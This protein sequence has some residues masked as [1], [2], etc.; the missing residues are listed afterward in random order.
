MPSDQDQDGGED[1]RASHNSADVP[2]GSRQRLRRGIP[3]RRVDLARRGHARQ[4]VVAAVVVVHLV[5]RQL[6]LGRACCKRQPGRRPGVGLWGPWARR[7]GVQAV[8]LL[9]WQALRGASTMHLEEGGKRGSLAPRRPSAALED[10]GP[11]E[12][13]SSSTPSPRPEETVGPPPLLRVLVREVRLLT[14]TRAA[15]PDYQSPRSPRAC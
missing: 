12:A 4:L 8:W 1:S 3:E 9:F 6:W 13:P 11:W 14:L 2:P 7:D 5:A 10:S 15:S